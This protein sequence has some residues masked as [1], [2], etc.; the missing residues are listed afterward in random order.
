MIKY[1]FNL[2]YLPICEGNSCKII[3]IF[4]K[5]LLRN[6]QFIIGPY[7]WFNKLSSFAKFTK[8]PICFR[9]DQYFGFIISFKPLN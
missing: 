6:W 5:L 2:V 9:R 7:L 4:I 3:E 1:C 8:A